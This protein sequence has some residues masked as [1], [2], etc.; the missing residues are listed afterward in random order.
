MASKSKL[1]DIDTYDPK[2]ETEKEKF[3][4]ELNDYIADKWDQQKNDE[5][6]FRPWKRD[7]CEE[8]CVYII[9]QID[10]TDPDK[11]YYKVGVSKNPEQRLKQLQTSNPFPL[12]LRMTYSTYDFYELEKMILENFK[13]FRQRGEWLYLY[14]GLME[15]FFVDISEM[16]GVIEIK[17]E[18]GS[19][20]SRLGR[21]T[22]HPEGCNLYYLLRTK[23]VAKNMM[24]S[25]MLKKYKKKVKKT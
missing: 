10:E 17:E 8:S 5:L 22:Y 2:N 7:D 12:S 1:L 9:Q 24:P 16:A 21:N 25:K 13:R 15:D 6:G 20:S 19:I 11:S 3:L 4:Q 14:D 23:Y 18:D